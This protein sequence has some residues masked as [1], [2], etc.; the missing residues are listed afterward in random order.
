MSEERAWYDFRTFD[1]S[2]TWLLNW[3]ALI[4][5]FALF[6]AIFIPFSISFDDI[7]LMLEDSPA[8]IGINASSYFF[9]FI[10]ILFIMNTSFFNADGE[11]ILNRRQIIATYMQ[12]TFV[13]DLLSTIPFEYITTENEILRSFGILKIFR[14]SR[15]SGLINKSALDEETKSTMRIAY[16]ILGLV[17]FLHS[18]AAM[19]H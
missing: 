18:L 8:Y 14:L 12:T 19:W 16:I 13:V 1:S 6:N 10:D 17:L 15:L 11:E 3:D 7:A 4:I 5:C 9:F 2:D